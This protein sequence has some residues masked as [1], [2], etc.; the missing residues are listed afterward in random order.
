MSDTTD[1]ELSSVEGYDMDEEPY[2]TPQVARRPE[3]TTDYDDE[4][5]QTSALTYSSKLNTPTSKQ[6]QKKP[7]Y[8]VGKRQSTPPKSGERI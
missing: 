2:T 8:Q 7:A 5:S 6:G 1:A 4:D 3:E